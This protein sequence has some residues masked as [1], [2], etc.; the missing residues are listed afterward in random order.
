[1]KN[2][3]ARY[4][5]RLVGAVALW[6]I[7]WRVPVK[8]Y[9]LIQIEDIIILRNEAQYNTTLKIRCDEIATQKREL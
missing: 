2:D 3:M 6:A 4:I 1:M 8:K 7:E 5:T 9:Y